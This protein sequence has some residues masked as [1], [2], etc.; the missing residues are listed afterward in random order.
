MARDVRKDRACDGGRG[1]S[2]RPHTPR[3]LNMGNASPDCSPSG[4]AARG[5]GVPVSRHPS[6]RREMP[7]AG[8]LLPP[9]WRVTLR[10]TERQVG[11]ELGPQAHTTRA[12]NARTPRTL[13][14]RPV[15]GQPREGE[16][17]SSGAPRQGGRRPP[18]RPSANLQRAEHEVVNT[19]GP[20][21]PVRPVG[22]VTIQP[23]G[24]ALPARPGGVRSGGGGA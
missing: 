20:H 17:L 15:D 18:G 23:M 6:S 10:R 14:A 24:P 19:A 3:P 21:T 4:R 13:T 5:W 7:P 12:R 22:A 2:P 1:G 11:N 8:A 16:C 9:P